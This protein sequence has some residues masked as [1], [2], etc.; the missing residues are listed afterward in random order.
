MSGARCP[1][2]AALA[3]AICSAA[4][5]GAQD[6]LSLPATEAL[7]GTTRAV[8]VSVRDLAG[9]TLDEGD[10]A[11]F[12]IQGFSFKVLFSPAASV[13]SVDFVQSGVTAGKNATFPVITPGVDNIFV[14]LNFDVETD[15]LAFTLDA[16][17][18]G[19]TIGELLFTISPSATLG[20]TIL[21]T[22]D[23]SGNAAL[24]NDAATLSETAANGQLALVNGSIFLDGDVFEN[25][26]EDGDRCGWSAS[27]PAD[28]C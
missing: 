7:P 13:T 22:I 8:A 18:P 4:A 6:S 11:N 10:G 28:T 5:A 24:V 15:P 25:G 14:I 3:L 1:A 9:T 21:L 26:F 2:L 20:S 12:E 19:N 16:A 17:A 27:V 23:S